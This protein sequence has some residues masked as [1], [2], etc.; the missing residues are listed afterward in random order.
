MSLLRDSVVVRA[1]AVTVLHNKGKVILVRVPTVIRV[2]M[3]GVEEMV[4]QEQVVVEVM[5]Q[6]ERMARVKVVIGMEETQVTE[7]RLMVIRR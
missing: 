4:T 1:C 7:A 3:V 6:Q 2:L 5:A